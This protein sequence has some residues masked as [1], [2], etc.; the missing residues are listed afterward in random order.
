MAKVIQKSNVDWALRPSQH[1]VGHHALRGIASVSVAIMHLQMATRLGFPSLQTHLAFFANEAVDLFFILSGFI[2]AYVYAGEG[3]IDWKDFFVARFARIYPVYLLSMLVVMALDAVTL[4]R[5]GVAYRSLSPLRIL[6]NVL[7]VQA[8][9]GHATSESINLPA[10][11]VSVEIFLYLATFPLMIA[12][13]G[14]KLKAGFGL[15]LP[16]CCACSLITAWCYVAFEGGD[17]HSPPRP[18]LRGIAGFVAGFVMCGFLR[19]RNWRVSWSSLWFCIGTFGLVLVLHPTFASGTFAARVAAWAF[20]A[21]IVYG[22]F[23]NKSL[24]GRWFSWRVFDVLGTLSFSLYLWH[25]PVETVLRR[26][27]KFVTHDSEVESSRQ[28]AWMLLIML[29]LVSI[30]S[31]YGIEDPARRRIRMYFGAKKNRVPDDSPQDDS[32][33]AHGAR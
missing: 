2:F 23:D 14:R 32:V 20:M 10:W 5:Y 22:T 19:G 17:L 4:L 12:V 27:L 16:V 9:F 33:P 28:F 31:Y 6:L 25:I 24:P 15:L 7:G 18:V 21:M 3:R 13:F 29:S 1:I 11:S 8:W 30:V 26:V